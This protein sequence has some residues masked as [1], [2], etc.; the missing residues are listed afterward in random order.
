MIGGDAEVE[1]DDDEE[2]EIEDGAVSDP[3]VFSRED[4]D[5]GIV[6]AVYINA[7]TNTWFCSNALS[8]FDNQ[9]LV[10][11][12]KFWLSLLILMTCI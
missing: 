12:L 10:L 9:I 4:F 3:L 2:E 7:V 5:S 8:C 11:A 1:D 6:T